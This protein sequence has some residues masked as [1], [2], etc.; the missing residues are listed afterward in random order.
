MLPPS[1]GGN[2]K[3]NILIDEEHEEKPGGS[4]FGVT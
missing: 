2:K 3:A 1:I 4:G